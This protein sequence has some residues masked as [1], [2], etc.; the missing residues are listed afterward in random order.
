[1]GRG[2]LNLYKIHY[3]KDKKGNSPIAEY[4]KDLSKKNNKDSRIKLQKILDYIDYLQEVGTNAG[5]PYMKHLT[6]DIWELRPLRDRV[7]FVAWDG[8]SFV[9]LSHFM[10]K[11][12]KTPRTKRLRRIK[13]QNPIA[14]KRIYRHF[15]DYMIKY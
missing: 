5:E 3:F 14:E 12:Q 13:N 9:L 4:L 6:G 11:T 1:M 8:K 10:K 7:L 2:K 15:D